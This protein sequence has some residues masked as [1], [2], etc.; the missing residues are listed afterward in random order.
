[1]V[2]TSDCESKFVN[3]FFGCSVSLGDVVEFPD[4]F[5]FLVFIEKGGL[6]SGEE[7]RLGRPGIRS[8]R[9]FDDGFDVVLPPS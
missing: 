4:G 5:F 1:V 7:Y 3:V 2:G 9:L 8:I 6:E